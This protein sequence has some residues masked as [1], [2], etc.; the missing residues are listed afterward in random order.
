MKW[1]DIMKGISWLDGVSKSIETFERYQESAMI[2]P[3]S[4]YQ[5]LLI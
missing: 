2:V 4:V 5:N 1:E 3:C